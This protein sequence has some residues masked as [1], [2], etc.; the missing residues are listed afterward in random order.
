MTQP[1][2]AAG[3]SREVNSAATEIPFERLAGRPLVL[4]L[5]IDGTLAPI[6]PHPS[7]AR[8][9]AETRRVIAS[10]VA[11]PQVIVALVS[12][13]GAQDARRLVGVEKLWTIGNH[14]AE[15][16]TPDGDISVDAAVASYAAP[17][18]QTAAALGPLLDPLRGV[19]LEN[20]TWTLSV[21]YRMADDGVLPRLRGVVDRVVARNGL[22]VTEGR[23][24]LEI[25]PPVAVDKGTAIERLAGDLGA[26]RD[27]AS[28]L[29]AG[30]DTTDEDAFR[31][32]RAECP[33]AVT[34]QV[35]GTVPTSAEFVVGSPDDI[36]LL[37]QRI[38]RDDDERS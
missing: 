21:H 32:L 35:G 19:V 12:G 8:V 33:K 15:L 30:D 28:L 9:P 25:R 2:A 14:G 13:R 1:P 23:M 37:L 36:R 24:V 20:K 27:G 5:D 16:M 11:R 34:V 10:L 38:A 22:R 29:F 6:A 3:G 26:L 4:M 18:A 7:L 17:M 31:L